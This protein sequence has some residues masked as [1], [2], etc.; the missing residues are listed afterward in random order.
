[1]VR[2]KS[3]STHTYTWSE[4]GKKMNTK[5]GNELNMTFGWILE[6]GS[7]ELALFE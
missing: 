6:Y 2:I 5:K 3:S 1:M 4:R 7:N